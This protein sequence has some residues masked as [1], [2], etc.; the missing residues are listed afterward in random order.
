MAPHRAQHHAVRPAPQHRHATRSPTSTT[1][2]PRPTS[3]SYGYDSFYVKFDYL[4]NDKHRTFASQTQNDG[5]AYRQQQRHR[6]RATPPPRAAT[7]T[8]ASHYGATLD[9][10]WTA[11]TTTVLNVRLSWDRFVDCNRQD[12]TDASTAP[13]SASRAARRQPRR[14]ASPT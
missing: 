13:H 10:V 9:H 11:T 5:Y 8:A 7:P 3:A 12:S 2:R 14:R 1:S 4:W 6:R